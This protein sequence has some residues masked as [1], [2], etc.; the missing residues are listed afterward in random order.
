MSSPKALSRAPVKGKTVGAK[1][2][3]GKT[4]ASKPSAKKP[5]KAA[6]SD[7]TSPTPAQKAAFLKALAAG[8]KPNSAASRSLV[9][10]K[11]SP[12][13]AEPP[14][15]APKVEVLRR[16]PAPV[17]VVDTP[18]SKTAL[19]LAI[20]ARFSRTP[21]RRWLQLFASSMQRMRK[22]GSVSTFWASARRQWPPPT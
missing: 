19:A 21:S 7:D 8:V 17:K 18:E 12:F 22:Q 5:A 11:G 9:K 6:V 16:I 10:K 15:P 3:V 14:K 13:A 2:A 1:P 4:V 20:W